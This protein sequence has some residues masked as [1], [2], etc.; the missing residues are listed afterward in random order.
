MILNFSYN[1]PEFYA[2]AGTCLR[3]KCIANLWTIDGYLRIQ[4]KCSDGL[5]MS[6]GDFSAV[7][8]EGMSPLWN[9]HACFSKL[10]R[11][12][13]TAGCNKTLLHIHKGPGLLWPSRLGQ[14]GIY[15]CHALSLGVQD[16]SQPLGGDRI[17]F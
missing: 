9:T 8:T 4:E 1:I 17:N 16:V 6:G 13:E 14:Q 12:E 10:V 15:L 11:K 3:A 7:G 2:P 5:Q